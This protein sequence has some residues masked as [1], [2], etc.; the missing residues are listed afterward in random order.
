MTV[1]QIC[2]VELKWGDPSYKNVKCEKFRVDKEDFLFYIDD[3]IVLIV[4]RENVLYV[5]HVGDTDVS[6][7]GQDAALH[8]T[9]AAVNVGESQKP[10]PSSVQNSG[11]NE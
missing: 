9:G 2:H 11:M 7:G 6:D 4:P 3:S 10:Q 5:E 1:M 8:D